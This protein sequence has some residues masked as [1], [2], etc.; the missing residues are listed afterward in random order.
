MK[1]FIEVDGH[2]ASVAFDPE[3]GMLRGEFLG[4]AGGADFYAQSVEQ[5]YAEGAKSL[6]IFHGICR[7]KGVETA[8]QAS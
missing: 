8:A 1:N 6:A 7:E 3:I 4:L 5:L 2:K